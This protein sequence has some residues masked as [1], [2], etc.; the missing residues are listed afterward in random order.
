M[1]YHKL[2]WPG[3][4]SRKYME[5]FEIYIPLYFISKV[6]SKFQFKFYLLAMIVQL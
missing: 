4:L 1:M 5:S 3:P 2:N 6:L